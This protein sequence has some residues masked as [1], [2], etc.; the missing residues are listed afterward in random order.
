METVL[1]KSMTAGTVVPPGDKSISHRAAFLGAL[2]V[3]G[4][5]VDNFSPGADCASTLK[6]LS[7][8]GCDVSMDGSRVGVSKGRFF[9]APQT[10]LDAGNS[11]TTARLLVGLLAGIPGIFAILSGDKSLRARPMGRVVHPL[12]SMGAKIDGTDGGE[13]LPLAIRG[14]RLSGGEHIPSAASA[15]VKTALLLAGLSASGSTTV[16]EPLA[17]RDHTERMLSFLQVPVLK[18]KNSVTIYPCSEVPGGSWIIPGDF[19][20]AAFWIVA[21]LLSSE[22]G[23]E[24]RNTGVNPTRTGMLEVLE[25]MGAVPEMSNLRQWGGEEVADIRIGKTHLTSTRVDACEVPLMVD[26]L[27]LIALAA[28]QADG[29]TEISGAGE[30][31]VKECDRIHAVAEGLSALGAKITEKDDGWIIEGPCSL[32]GGRVRTYHDHRMVMTFSI[33]SLVAEGAVLPDETESAGISDPA[34]MRELARLTG[35]NVA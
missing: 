27:P 26:E 4:I 13:R 6:C 28:T 14:V 33:A 12:Q 7:L 22:R 20:A 32:S 9:A 35:G 18:D 15:Q 10:I 29:V 1:G 30:L 17:T 3:H 19:S 25:R 5:R 16:R 2:S 11:G 24:I 23:L 34:F 31:R 21:G 8:L